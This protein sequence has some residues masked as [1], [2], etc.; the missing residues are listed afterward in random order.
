MRVTKPSLS[1]ERS[2][3]LGPRCGGFVWS[4]PIVVAAFRVL[5]TYKAAAVV[6]Q[7]H[8]HDF[9]LA[10]SGRRLLRDVDVVQATGRG[11]AFNKLVDDVASDHRCG[12]EVVMRVIFERHRDAGDAEERTFNRG[13]YG[14]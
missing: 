8:R 9:D 5:A 2:E 10:R 11:G 4:R 7:F 6:R 13:G 1:A 14:A 3:A 12:L